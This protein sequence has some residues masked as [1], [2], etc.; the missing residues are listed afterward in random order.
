MKARIQLSALL[1]AGAVMGLMSRT[2]VGQAPEAAMGSA[3]QSAEGRVEARLVDEPSRRVVKMSN[4]FTIILQQ[5]KTAPVVAARI[6]IRAGALTEQQ[7]MAAGISHVVEHLVAG[8]SSGK[9]KESENTLLLQQIGNDSNAYTEADSTVYFI[10]TTADKWATAMDLLVDFTTNSDFTREQ[11]DREFKVVQREIEMDEEETDRIFYQQTQENR[12]IQSP[13]RHPVVGYKTAFQKITFEDC[14]A[15]FQE[16]YVPDNMVISVAGDLDLASAE[17]Q[18]VE[19]LK[20]VKRKRVPAIAL[21][22]EPAVVAT[23]YSAMHDEKG[24][25]KQARINWAFPTVSLY[26]P[27]LYAADML[28]SVLGGSESSVLVRKLRDELGL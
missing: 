11:F 9:R 13:A 26:D 17:K 8:A 22:S 5:N 20:D 7:H 18:I 21:P 12:Y 19:M 23:R 27:D 25:I 14:K 16:M 28:A 1:L 24:V 4:G 6:Y 10:T 15:Y 3:D 2:A